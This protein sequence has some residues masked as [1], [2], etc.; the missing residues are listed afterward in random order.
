MKNLSI[1]ILAHIDAGK[2]STTE[3][4]LFQAGVIDQLGSVDAGNTQTDS[5]DQERRRGITIQAAVTA[6]RIGDIQVNLVDTPGHPD[7]IA[8]IERVLD[9]L[10]GAILVVSSV[11]GVQAQTRVLYRA[12][13]RMSIPCLIFANKIDRMGARYDSLL[14][15]IRS[16]LTPTIAPLGSCNYIGQ[17][18]A[19]FSLF[20]R[21][22]ETVRAG[23]IEVLADNDED[24]LRRFVDHG[25]NIEEGLIRRV[26]ICQT[27]RGFIH[28]ILFGSAIT[29]AGIKDL[30]EAIAEFLPSAHPE[31][32]A[33][34]SGK[35][36][37]IERGPS[38]E[39]ICYAKV[40][41]GTVRARDRIKVGGIDQ[42]VTAIQV[43]ENGSTVACNKVEAGR[44]A[45]LRGLTDARIGDSLGKHDT[46]SSELRF[47]PPMMETTIS[48]R[49]PKE[50]GR[51]FTALSQL[52]EQDPFISLRVDDK[53][54]A[55]HVSLYGEVQREVIEETLT[56]EY[57]LKVDFSET[58][59]IHVERPAGT[60][61]ALDEAPDP[62]VATIG[63]TV[64]PRPV[65]AGN[66]FELAVEPGLLPAGFFKAV[67]DAVME[68]LR[69][70][71]YG[72]QVIDCKVTMTK[73]IR[74]RDWANSTA[75][76]HRKL[77]PLVVMDALRQAGSKVHEPIQNFHL[78]CPSDSVGAL[79]SEMSKLRAVPN[80][81]T[82][83]GAICSLEGTIPASK[84]RELQ[85]LLPGLTRGEGFLDTDFSHYA[86]VIGDYPVRL[87]TDNNPLDRKVYLRLID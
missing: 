60:G 54:G 58:T 4:L 22:P 72:W 51:L 45:K 77:A 71:L 36:F 55:L 32:D 29:G 30:V 56:T 67:E 44:V 24:I 80:E 53:A 86:P 50:K 64:E 33:A 31:T 79:I 68:T 5:M 43:F 81:P 62:F 49:D 11:E 65:D 8:E 73:T 3:R 37:K 87:R 21:F 52:A 14:D 15:D 76:D 57:K 85:L 16:R 66:V 13:K 70:G 48:A 74:Y 23:L 38:G 12:L 26:L 63:L 61:E 34:L 39:K 7:F 19:S 18:T 1:G 2:T 9:V 35:V 10:D 46:S 40:V 78:E 17:P 59:I 69:Q 83:R 84:V 25:S 20:D 28:P 82:V 41:S 42:R 47:S 27:R 6:F 75:A